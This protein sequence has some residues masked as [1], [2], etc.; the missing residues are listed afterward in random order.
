MI[1][2]AYISI[3]NSGDSVNW[4][5]NNGDLNSVIS[6]IVMKILIMLR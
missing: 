3:F 6:S 5:K 1:F 2:A 4:N